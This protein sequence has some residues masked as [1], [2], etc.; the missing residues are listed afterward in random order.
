MGVRGLHAF[1]QAYQ[2]NVSEI[3]EFPVVSPLPHGDPQPPAT[4][5]AVDAWAWLYDAWL[6]N[7]G[8]AVQGGNYK[9]LQDYTLD[10]ISAWR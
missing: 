4:T 1:A 2:A 8:E 6:Q 3:R 7:F 9:D 5:L 10:T